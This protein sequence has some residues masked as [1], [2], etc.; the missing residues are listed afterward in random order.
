MATFIPFIAQFLPLL[1]K[2][3]YTD[4]VNFCAHTNIGLLR[5]ECFAYSPHFLSCLST[6]VLPILDGHAPHFN[7]K[8]YFEEENDTLSLIDSI[9]KFPQVQASSNVKLYIKASLRP[10]MPQLSLQIDAISDWLN[11]Q[12]VDPPTE[13]RSLILRTANN[14][15][16]V[17]FSSAIQLIDTLKVVS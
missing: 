11:R 12:Y 13:Y 17:R 1:R 5:S 16:L 7:F 15:F 6:K 9:L 8:V 4:S 2:F 3:T 14:P 10:F